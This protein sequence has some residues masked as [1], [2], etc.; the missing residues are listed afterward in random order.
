MPGQGRHGQRVPNPKGSM[1][2]LRL[3]EAQV[4]AIDR[5]RRPMKLPSRSAIVREA[6]DRLLAAQAPAIAPAAADPAEPTAAAR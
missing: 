2:A 3:T 5:L 1:I 4:K 6:L